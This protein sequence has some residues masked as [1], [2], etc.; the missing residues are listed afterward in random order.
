MPTPPTGT[1]TLLFTDIEGSTRL[2][3]QLGERYPDVLAVHQLLLR[4]ACQRWRGYEVRTEGDSFFVAFARAG[5]AVAAAV[6]A[7]QALVA[8]PWPDGAAVRVRMGLH[9]GEPAYIGND[10]VG[11]DVHRAARLAAAGHGGQVLLSRTTYDLVEH[12]LP[13]GVILSDLGT[14]RLKD[15]L[16]PEQL[17]QLVIADLPGTFA[18][19]KTIAAQLTNLPIQATAL[20]GRERDIAS[21]RDLL[22]RDDVRLVT[23]TG[24]GG[25]GK[26][27]LALQA[28]TEMLDTFTDGVYFVDLAPISDS[29]LVVSTIAQTLGIRESGSVPLNEHLTDYLRPKYMLLVLDNF[30]QV[31]AAASLISELLA[32]AP[33][34]KVLVTSRAVLHLYGE[35]E[36]VVSGLALPDAQQLPPLEQ[37]TQYDAVWLFIERAQAAKAD[38]AVTNDNAPAVAEICMRLDGLPLAI[39]LAAA[40]SKLFAPQALLARLTNRL[41]LLVGGPRDLPARQQTL[42]STIDWSY[43]LLNAGEQTLFRRLSVFVGGC[44]LE[45]AEAVCNT[46]DNLSME[47]LD[48]LSSLVDKSLLKQVEGVGGEPRFVM[49]ETI[50]EYALEKLDEYDEM[51]IFQQQH[52]AY[53]LALAETAHPQLHG[54]HMLV[55]LPRLRQNYSNLLKALAWYH[56]RPDDGE[57]SLRL[58]GAL[59]FFWWLQGL[60]SEGRTW[61]REVLDRAHQR[62]ME[63]PAA[64]AWAAFGAGM[65]EHSN[66]NLSEAETL[67]QLSYSCACQAA[68]R[69][70]MADALDMLFRCA[71]S[72]GDLANALALITEAVTLCREGQHM[73][74]LGVAL[75]HLAG[76]HLRRGNSDEAQET[77]DECYRISQ[78]LGNPYQYAAVLGQS[79]IFALYRDDDAQAMKYFEESVALWQQI[80]DHV[81]LA[82]CLAWLGDIARRQQKDTQAVRRYHESL[83]LTEKTGN[84]YCYAYTVQK[85]GQLARQNG[86][87]QQ[88]QTSYKASLRAYQELNDQEGMAVA[89]ATLGYVALHQDDAVQAAACFRESLSLSR[90]LEDRGQ[91]GLGVL[92]FAGVALLRGQA[93]HAVRLLG[94][95]KRL[96]DTSTSP[97]DLPDRVEHDWVKNA[98]QVQLDEATF[99]TM[100]AEGQAL[101]LEQ[102]IDEAL[103]APTEPKP[104]KG[105][106]R[107]SHSPAST[108][109]YP[110]GLTEREVDILRLVAQ[111]LTDAQVAERLIISPRTVQGHLR[112]IYG[113]LDVTSRTAASR[114]AIKHGLL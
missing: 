23:L 65:L 37:L 40:R 62:R 21:V 2:L 113:K 69:A 56:H 43:N 90:N 54:P 16:R 97:I 33:T 39:E 57:M 89:Q 14:H 78:S 26:T 88:A 104:L 82:W 58:A 72:R 100:W 86:D 101:P 5:D 80:G 87:Y 76:L 15:L 94:A 8:H 95:A 46:D 27:R 74:E 79:G 49:L 83:A 34:L 41:K 71:D 4:T 114:F 3:Q 91:I 75:Q 45:A 35:R 77:L 7:Q 110:S 105:V 10:Y 67:S 102:V 112:S 51:A 93:I 42:R 111:G 22:R 106:Q 64:Y 103:T 20:I 19:L 60:W 38:F 6:A 66:G 36:F 13:A 32:A 50:L 73:F 92:G 17:F 81:N 47:V 55:W 48:G 9:T 108:L 85:L 1:V 29:S 99:A 25:I 11:L 107:T 59:W 61:L 12:D 84:K 44:T 30:E 24:P 18:P 109:P 63:M 96:L 28:A 53:Y 68:N 31:L 98:L 52:A 70:L